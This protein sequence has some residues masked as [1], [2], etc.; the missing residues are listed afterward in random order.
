MAA[1]DEALLKLERVSRTFR[2][3]EVMI[4]VLRE[5]T[6]DVHPGELLAIVG[7]S[8]SGKTTLLNLVGG[9]D[10]PSSGKIVFDGIDLTSA[11]SAELTRYRREHVGFIFQFFNLVPNL[12]ARENVQIAAEI[13]AE[14]R[15]SAEVLS[16]VE[17]ADRAD[18][19]PS[20]LSGGEQQRVAIARAI[21][22]N[23]ALLLCD[24]P[25]GSLDLDTG[26]RI[27][28]LLVDLNNKL[29][30]TVV[31]ITHNVAIAGVADRVVHIG[32]GQIRDIDVHVQRR[33]PEEVQW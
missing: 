17:L 32:S 2:L 21:V 5:I 23:P 14:P 26:R 33:S 15:D 29:E 1:G 31:I 16:L 19:F 6:L 22:K 13:C 20:Q 27:L 3:G 30:T 25:T 28:R 4:N 9:M 10:H 12:T 24:E 7:P 11:D 18:H 8:G